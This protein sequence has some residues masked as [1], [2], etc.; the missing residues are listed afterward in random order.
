[1]RY[2]DDGKRAEAARRVFYDMGSSGV[3][4]RIMALAASGLALA[5]SL[6]AAPAIAA[7]P[8]PWQLGLPEPATPI[9]EMLTDFHTL[10]LWIITI[11]TIFV[12]V[13]L[14]WT[15]FKF[16]ESAN[17]TPSK[18]T[19][20]AVLEVAWTL[21]PIL[22]L[23]GIAFPSFKVMYAADS[24]DDAEMTLKIT[25]YQWYWNYTYPDHGNFTFDAYLLARTQ[26]EASEQN[27][28]RLMDTD[29]AVVLPVDTNIRLIITAGDVLHNWSM[30]DFGVR[31]DA[32][33]GRL[34]E[35]WTRINPEYAGHT[36]YG[37]C[38]ELCGTDHAYMPIMVKAVTKEEFAAWVEEAQQQFDTAD[39]SPRPSLENDNA[40]TSQ[41]AYTAE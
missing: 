37:F 21:I 5:A 27:A 29:N 14:L 35:T 28:H 36:F 4:S 22:I 41:L 25:G 6:V 30:S 38:S 31:L 40:G 39:G 9:A 17:P 13:L 26:E 33:P 11:I 8:E 16:R 10:L 19:H 18:T 15:C 7:K 20:N 2:I 12:L 1:M 32:V 3:K 23:V 24:T 34:N